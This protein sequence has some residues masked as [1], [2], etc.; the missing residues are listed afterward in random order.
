MRGIADYTFV[1]PL[2]SG[3]HGHYYLARTPARLP[4]D[5]EHDRHEWC[6]LD[7][8]LAL[9]FYDTTKDAVRAAAR[10]LQ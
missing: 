9:L 1:R 3:N 5:A 8:A 6:D 2:G 7:E 4:V 10:E